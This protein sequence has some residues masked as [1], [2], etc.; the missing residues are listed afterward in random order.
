MK[1]RYQD[2]D[3]KFIKYSL[4]LEVDDV[5]LFDYYIESKSRFQ[6][7]FGFFDVRGHKSLFPGNI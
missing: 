4:K 7:Q 2:I 5:Y 1:L 3:I 6:N